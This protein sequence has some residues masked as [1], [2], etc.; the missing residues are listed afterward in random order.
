MAGGTGDAPR[1]GRQEVAMEGFGLALGW[2]T[3]F[4]ALALGVWL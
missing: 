4:I 2:I 1:A 3:L